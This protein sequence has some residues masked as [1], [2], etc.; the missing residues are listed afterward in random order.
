M[1]TTFNFYAD[2]TLSSRVTGV[3]ALF[4]DTGNTVAQRQVWLGS[5]TAGRVLTAPEGG[6]VITVSLAGAAATRIRLGTTAQASLNATAG[7]PLEL[8]PP[9]RAPR[10][11]WLTLDAT[12]QDVGSQTA[13]LSLAAIE[14]QLP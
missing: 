5:R 8:T 12:G 7:A 3:A 11:L 10:A 9:T 4:P 13:T 2:A 1:P 14:E 6:S